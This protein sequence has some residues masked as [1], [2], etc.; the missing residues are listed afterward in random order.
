MN[1]EETI[2][3]S[4]GSLLNTLLFSPPPEDIHTSID[5][6][7]DQS[8]SETLLHLDPVE[9]S[10][11]PVSFSFPDGQKEAHPFVSVAPLSL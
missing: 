10:T 8:G 11:T 7:I 4:P 6:H 3:Q 1:M 2:C 9:E 5:S